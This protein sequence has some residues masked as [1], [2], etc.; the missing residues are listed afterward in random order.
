[1]KIIQT[2]TGTLSNFKEF[3]KRTY[4]DGVKIQDSCPQCNTLWEKDLSKNPLVYV[5]P[6]TP[7]TITGYCVECENEWSVG[8]IVLTAKVVVAT[9]E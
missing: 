2:D 3:P 8:Q 4:L 9:W 7:V 1:M 6:D 5:Q